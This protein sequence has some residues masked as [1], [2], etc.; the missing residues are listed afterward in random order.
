MYDCCPANGT[1]VGWMRSYWVKTNPLDFQLCIKHLAPRDSRRTC[2]RL[3]H[4]A[5]GELGQIQFLLG[6]AWARII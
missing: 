2:A 1:G 6:A 5:G 3:S 4:L